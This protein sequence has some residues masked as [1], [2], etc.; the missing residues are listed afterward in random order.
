MKVKAIERQNS[1][2]KIIDQTKLPSDLIY[3]VLDDYQQVVEA[4]KTLIAY[5][6]CPLVLRQLLWDHDNKVMTRNI[7][8]NSYRWAAKLSV[9]IESE[10]ATTTTTDTDILQWLEE[11]RESQPTDCG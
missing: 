4:I 6:S 1:S 5:H 11:F 8:R 10:A 2:I 7:F 3:L 9:Q